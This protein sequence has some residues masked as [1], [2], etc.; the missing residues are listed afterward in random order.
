LLLP[1]GRRAEEAA[2]GAAPLGHKKPLL[3][4]KVKHKPHSKMVKHKPSAHKT[5]VYHDGRIPF[6]V[7]QDALRKR[8]DRRA[9]WARARPLL[10]PSNAVCSLAACGRLVLLLPSS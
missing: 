9:A 7:E 8:A 10:L 6:D 2:G 3:S 5:H 1:P 4:S